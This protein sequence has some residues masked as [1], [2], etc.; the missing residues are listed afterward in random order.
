ESM[1][2]AGALGREVKADLVLATDPDAD[3]LGAMAPDKNG[4][5]RVITGNEITALLTHFKLSK[6]AQFGRLPPSPIVL[7]AEVTT[8]VVTRIARHFKC[9]VIDHLLV[10]FKYVADVLWHLESEGMD[11]DVKGSPADFVIASEE[12]HGILLTPAIRDKDAGA[13]A[14]VLAELALDQKRKGKTVG[15]YLEQLWR[16]FGYYRNEGVAIFM[17]GVE[18][19]QQVAALLDALRA[20][21][22][23]RLAGLEVTYYEDLR[24]EEGKFGPLKGATDAASRNV[25]L[26]RC[27][28]RA[29]VAL[30]PSGTEPKAKMYL[31][32]CSGP[33]RPGTSE[34]AWRA[35]CR[36]VD[37]LMA[38][39][40]DDFAAQALGRIGLDPRAALA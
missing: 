32:A 11:D 38:R 35:A 17:R 14:L 20:D 33:R 40:R 23:R 34:E 37:E 22:P 29:R 16:D 10:G 30:R 27:G 36:E 4:A 1:D 26:F 9:Q 19:K 8:S 18:G 5:W 39:L 2:R 28:E 3:R 24:D 6:L 31:E 13:A 25:L 21:P 15:D 12:S 7:R